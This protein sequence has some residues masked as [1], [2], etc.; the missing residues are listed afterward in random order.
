ML[1]R[2]RLWTQIQVAAD[3]KS[4]DRFA[5][6]TGLDETFLSRSGTVLPLIIKLSVDPYNVWSSMSLNADPDNAEDRLTKNKL[7]A[8][9]MYR[10]IRPIMPVRHCLRLLNLRFPILDAPAAFEAPFP[11]TWPWR[12]D[13]MPKLHTP[14]AVHTR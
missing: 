8:A 5:K 12:L 2:H 13:N 1:G 14:F 6:S 10:Y 3:Y 7:A 11:G 4:V 9:S